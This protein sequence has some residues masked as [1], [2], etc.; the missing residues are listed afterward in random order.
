[1]TK[2]YL[3]LEILSSALK[4][5]IKTAQVFLLQKSKLRCIQ[6]NK[7]QDIS[8]ISFNDSIDIED[9]TIIASSVCIVDIS[10]NNIE[11]NPF[12]NGLLILFPNAFWINLS[13]NPLNLCITSNDCILPRALGELDIRGCML[14]DIESIRRFSLI[15]ILRLYLDIDSFLT[16]F[17]DAVNDWNLSDDV[18]KSDKL[19]YEIILIV[20]PLVWTING[21][22]ITT[23]NRQ[24]IP[25]DLL[26]Q[27][28]A[29]LNEESIITVSKSLCDTQ[30]I[31]NQ[32]NLRFNKRE[33][34]I[35]QY[36]LNI[37]LNSNVKSD[38][39]KL[40]IL[41]EDYLEESFIF[42]QFGVKNQ[43]LDSKYRPYIDLH[44]ILLLPHRLRLDLSVLLASSI[45]FHI[46]NNLL[47]N[48]LLIM[49]HKYIPLN[50]LKYYSILPCFIKTALISLIRRLCFREKLELD[51]LNC[52]LSK[53][54]YYDPSNKYNPTDMDTAI[55]GTINSNVLSFHFLRTSKVYLSQPLERPIYQHS[56]N[57]QPIGQNDYSEVLPSNKSR[58]K[59]FYEICDKY[60]E[61]KHH[62]SQESPF[63]DDPLTLTNNSP[64]KNYKD[65]NI[66]KFSELENE[67]L[68][69]LPD[70]VVQNL[71]D[72]VS[73]ST[74]IHH[75]NWI[76]LS[77]RHSVLLLAKSSLFPS[78]TR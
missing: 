43:R 8:L 72:D 68:S 10:R 18:K 7:I 25:K 61:L 40:D 1:M 5:D 47:S 29:F 26:N 22:Y 24:S 37:P 31:S 12:D 23:S 63:S 17:K 62:Y 50:Q 27:I 11:E 60:D 70:V 34:M 16:V 71:L 51:H 21:Q 77:S 78:L 46:P 52:L 58:K 19:N 6:Y 44:H 20:F 66:E 49:L 64:H 38:E 57:L 65:S 73:L 75:S 59:Y 4:A 35:L 28:N 56:E 76:S 45:L 14:N 36:L 39:F 41:L 9:S 33:D 30:I 3:S 15:N 69:V 53:P 74:E 48:T 54:E 67:L 2:E 55:D 42:N 32:F 13:Y